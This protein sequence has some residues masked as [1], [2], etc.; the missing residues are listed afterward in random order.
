MISFFKIFKKQIRCVLI[1]GM[2][3][4]GT[5]CLAGSLQQ[6]GLYLG[7]VFKENPH[8]RKGNRENARIME[9]NDCLLVYNKG[10]WDNPP[11]SIV[12]DES[13]TKERDQIIDD[14]NN[15]Q[16]SIWGFKDPRTLITLPFWMDN[17]KNCT[18][19]GT[20]R[21]PISV[22]NSLKQR[23]GMSIEHSL[24]L[25]ILYNRKLLELHKKY[26]FRLVSFDV[27]KDE[28]LTQ[29]EKIVANL[30]MPVVDEKNDELFFDDSLR[31]QQH[32]LNED[33]LREEVR[34]MYRQLVNIYENQK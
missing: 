7:N 18:F 12:W 3:R 22:S 28:Y 1:L 20:F 31:N 8:N 15:Q 10:S 32:I 34:I 9:L 6:R 23:N 2:H 13:L 19:V 30:K 21:N 11:K 27:T 14:F 33:S 5:S 24:N 26:N 17:L 4:S 16:Q 29:I 25:W